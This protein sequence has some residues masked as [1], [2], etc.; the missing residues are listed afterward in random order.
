MIRI[1]KTFLKKNTKLMN[2]KLMTHFIYGFPTENKSLEI[3]KALNKYGANI[4]EVQFP[5]SDPIA[6]G[7]TIIEACQKSLEKEKTIDN[8]ISFLEK[9]KEEVDIPITVMSYA[10][11]IYKFGIEK[12]VKEI[13]KIKVYGLIIPDLPFDTEEGEEL[14][15]ACKKYKVN[16]ILVLSPGISIERVKSLINFSK[17]FIYCTS[18]KGTTGGSGKFDK[19]LNKFVDE[20]RSLTKLPIAIGFGV[21]NKKDIK[22]LEKVADIVIAGSVFINE[23]Q[24]KQYKYISHTI[25]TTLQKIIG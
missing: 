20:L 1:L 17:G 19:N 14:L 4:L 8:F 11:P 23:I 12:F 3:A 25:K 2:K 16:P 15:N 18:K 5:F 9:I 21:K 24:R 6:D 10:N 22:Q 13:S 7:P